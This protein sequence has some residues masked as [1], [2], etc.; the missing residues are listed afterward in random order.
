LILNADGVFDYHHVDSPNGHVIQTILTHP[1][2]FLVAAGSEGAVWNYMSNKPTEDD[3][4]PEPYSLTV[5]GLNLNFT[6]I[7]INVPMSAVTLSANEE[8]L[9]F[10]T[11]DNQL[12]KMNISLEGSEKVN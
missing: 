5:N 3:P 4:D 12:Y 9:Y 6:E 10:T 8:I 2:G 7:K 1:R 11:Q